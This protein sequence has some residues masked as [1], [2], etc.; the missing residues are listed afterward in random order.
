MS[1]TRFDLPGRAVVV[2]GCGDFKILE[3]I[4]GALDELGL[5]PLD[6]VVVSGIGQAAKTPHYMKSHFFNGLHGR[7]LSNATAIKAANPSLEVIAVGGDVDMYGEGGNHFIHTIRRNPGITNLSSTTWSTGSP[8]GRHPPRRLVASGPLSRWTGFF[9]S[10]SIL[11]TALVQGAG[12]VARAFAGDGERTK[13]IIKQAVMH[14]GYSLV[15]IFQPCVSFNPVNTYKWFQENTRW[16]DGAH[17]PGDFRKA[18]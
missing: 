1:S 16:L 2:P 11:A 10:H 7:A 6:V 4:K 13:D 15:D 12:F 3:S 17:D 14:K 18:P 9:P 8:R 5:T